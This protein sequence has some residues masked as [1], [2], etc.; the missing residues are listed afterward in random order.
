M[1][2]GIGVIAGIF[3]ILGIT[4]ALFEEMNRPRTSRKSTRD[5]ALSDR[6][7]T[8][9]LMYSIPSRATSARLEL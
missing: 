1:V 2:L 3:L 4:P 9:R 8:K 6:E 7:K 5:P